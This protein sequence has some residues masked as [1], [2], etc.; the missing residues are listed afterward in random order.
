MG[1]APG[2][3]RLGRVDA[4]R[5]CSVCGSPLGGLHQLRR[6]PALRGHSSGGAGGPESSSVPSDAARAV[7]CGRPAF[8]QARIIRRAADLRL[9]PARLRN[10]RR[11]VHR[12]HLKRRRFPGEPL[13]A[14]RSGIIRAADR[15]VPAAERGAP[16]AYGAFLDYGDYALICNSPELL[17][18]VTRGACPA[19]GTSSPGQSKERVPA[20]LEW[21][22]SCATASRTRPSST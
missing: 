11:A 18:R 7:A 15:S 4:A 3:S 22:S 5:L 2:S 14:V 19:S 20:C 1:R 16:A 9:L 13:A 10:G 17:L 21:R 8:L 6:W 12:L